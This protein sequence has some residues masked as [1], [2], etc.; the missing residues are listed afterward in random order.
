I[1]GPGLVVAAPDGGE[2]LPRDGTYTV[3]WATSGSIANVRIE[4]SLNNGLAWTTLVG[5]TPNT[6]R[7]TWTLPATDSAQALI[8]VS[9]A[10]YPLVFDESNAGF[11]LQSA[12]Q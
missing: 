9:D 3:R 8:R 4:V 12:P 11:T 1:K 6:G 5:S 2:R 7:Y 10:A